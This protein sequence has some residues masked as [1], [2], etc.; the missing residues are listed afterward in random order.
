M[1]TLDQIISSVVNLGSESKEYESK[2]RGLILLGG[3]ILLGLIVLWKVW[4]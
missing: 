3:G 4:K 2:I 1:A